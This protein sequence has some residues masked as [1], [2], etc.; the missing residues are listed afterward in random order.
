MS[1]LNNGWKFELVDELVNGH[2]FEYDELK[3]RTIKVPHDFSVEQPLDW[4]GGSDGC[5]GYARGGLAWYRKHIEVTS[6]MLDKKVFINFDGIYNRAHIYFNEQLVTFHPYGYSP[7]LIDVTPYLKEGDNLLAVYV[8]HSRACDSRWYTGSG[9]YRKVSMHVLP[10]SYI[11]VWGIRVTTDCNSDESAIVNLSVDLVNESGSDKELKVVTTLIAPTGENVGQIVSNVVVTDTLKL[12]E[13]IELKN[14]TLWGIYEGFRYAAITAIYEGDQCIQTKETI[15]GIRYFHFDANEGFFLNGKNELIKGVCLH[16]DAGLVGSAIPNDV[17]RRRLEML[18]MAGTNA[19]RTAHNPYSADFFDLCDEYGILVQE[20]FYDEWDYPKGK[21]FNQKEKLFDYKFHGHDQFFREYAK[22]DLQNV[23]RRDFNH[24]CIIQWSIGNEIEWT[25]PKY[26]NA[27][28]YFSAEAGGGYFFKEPPYSVEE[29]RKICHDLPKEE[30]EIGK[31]AK[32]L[33]DWTRE[34]DTTRPIIANCILPSASYESGYVDALDMVGFSYRR[35]IYDRAHKHYPDKPIMGT[36]NVAQWHEWK[37]VLDRPFISG[38]F[39]WVGIDYVGECGGKRSDGRNRV[40]QAGFIDVA[41]FDK[42]SF[43]MVKA[44]WREDIPELFI[45]TNTLA[46]SVYDLQDGKLVQ[47]KGLPAWDRRLWVWQDMNTHFNYQPGEDVVVEVYS[48]CEEISF[49]QNDELICTQVEADNVDRIYKCAI[50]YKG[51]EIRAEG[52]K[53]GHRY[54][55]VIKES[56]EAT[57]IFI[58]VDKTEITTDFDSVVHVVAQLKDANGIEVR[59]KEEEIEFMTK[60]DVDG[61]VRFVGVDN[62]STH[63]PATYQ[64]PKIETHRGRALMIVGGNTPG[65]IKVCAK[66]KGHISNV[67]DITVK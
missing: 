42:P 25:Y 51:G 40:T 46:A 28:G 22:Q 49:Y 58:T 35:I 31:T 38:I 36:E 34:M 8:D 17:M 19:I 39:I 27:T 9:I 52:T 64:N 16:H 50:K 63:Y 45:T 67:I 18:I 33:A 37:A 44:L 43:H 2:L 6:N 26:N 55:S 21:K 61:I 48:N 59:F 7:C 12:N 56:Q 5:V 62:G 60:S 23:I 65:V 10:K 11:P 24:P 4:D 53:D 54:A 32:L 30:I 20:E 29:I 3:M 41:G 15:F 14:P 13:S 57:D 1:D 66:I 47:R